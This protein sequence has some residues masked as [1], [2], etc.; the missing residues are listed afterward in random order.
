MS[1]LGIWNKKKSC[2]VWS[3]FSFSSLLTKISLLAMFPPLQQ[4]VSSGLAS[5]GESRSLNSDQVKSTCC[6]FSVMFTPTS[7]RVCCAGFQFEACHL[8]SSVELSQGKGANREK[9]PALV[10]QSLSH[11]AYSHR[12]TDAYALVHTQ[13]LVVAAL[14]DRY[15]RRKMNDVSLHLP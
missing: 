12:H 10:K 3:N 8:C 11:Q 6:L 1:N 2:L 14:M 7:V 9:S 5:F 4:I 15:D 13:Q